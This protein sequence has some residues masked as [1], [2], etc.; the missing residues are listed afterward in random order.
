MVGAD[1]AA[2]LL[3]GGAQRKACEQGIEHVDFVEGDFRA[4]GSPDGAFDVVLCSFAIFL[5]PDMPGALTELWRMVAPGGRLGVTSWGPE[6]FEPAGS[7]WGTAL[8]AERPADQISTGPSPRAQWESPEQARALFAAGGIDAP[9]VSEYV[10]GS[11]PI[12]NG[13]DWWTIVLGTGIRGVIDSLGPDAAERV[14]SPPPPPSTPRVSRRS[15]PTSSTPS[16]PSPHDYR[17]SRERRMSAW[18]RGSGSM[19]RATTLMTS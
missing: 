10:P 15:S 8:N 17:K 11:H 2:P 19:R 9:M 3:R 16:P 1:L 4:L 7:I 13:D 12:R 6:L 5:V 18:P 14:A